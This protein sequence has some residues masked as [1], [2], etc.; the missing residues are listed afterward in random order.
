MKKRTLKVRV[1]YEPNRLAKQ[2]L[3]EAYQRFV[4]MIKQRININDEKIEFEE[5]KMESK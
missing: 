5:L 4:P 3:S 1:S 2:Y